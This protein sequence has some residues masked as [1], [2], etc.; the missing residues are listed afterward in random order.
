M[1]VRIGMKGND[2][3]R[4][5]PR[6]PTHGMDISIG[7]TGPMDMVSM[8]LFNYGDTRVK[9]LQVVMTPD[10]ARIMA[11]QLNHYADQCEEYQKKKSQN[12]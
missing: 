5:K 11:K 6:Q 7:Y 8:I 2:A 3:F 10:R 9:T 4:I 1:S 12:P